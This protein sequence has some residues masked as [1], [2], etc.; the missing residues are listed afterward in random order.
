MKGAIVWGS[1]A[2]L[3]GR[4]TPFRATLGLTAIF[5]LGTS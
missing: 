2:D 1:A 4:K 3:V 5:G